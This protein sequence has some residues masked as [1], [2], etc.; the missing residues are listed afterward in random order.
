[1]YFE[2]ARDQ[3]IA[4]IQLLESQKNQLSCPQLKIQTVQ[5]FLDYAKSMKLTRQ[6][7]ETIVE[8]A[9][10]LIDQFYA[11]LPYKRARYATDPVQRLRLIHAQLDHQSD[12]AFHEQMIQVFMRLRDAHTFYGLPRPFRGAFAFLPFRMEC[13]HDKSGHR[14]FLVT[15]VLEGFDHAR[16]ALNAEIVCWNG[17]P[18]E[19]AIEREADLE[20]GGNPASRFVRGMKR[21]TKRSLAFSLPPDESYAVLQYLPGTRGTEQYSIVLPWYVATECLPVA[22]R[23]GSA[24]SLNESLSELANLSKMLW[25]RK[26]RVQEASVA[27]DPRHQSIY[28]HVFEFQYSSGTIQSD[29]VNPASLHDPAYPDQ[30]FGYIRISAFDIDPS[31]ENDSGRFVA[32]FI[33]ILDI[34]RAEAPDGLILDVRSNPGG[35]IDAAERILQLLTPSEIQPAKFHFINSRMTQHIASNLREGTSKDPM[36][37]NHREWLPWADDL[38]ASVSSGH[39]VTPGKPLT[40]FD[41]AND[42]GQRYQS[43][44]MLIVDALSYSA[45][46]LFAAGFQDHQI[47]PIIGVDDNTGGGGAN[48]W[49][50]EELLLKLAGFSEVPLKKLPGGA[51]LGLA[52]RRSTR[53]GSNAG[54]VVEDLGVRCDVKYRITRNDL[55]HHDSDLIQFACHQLGMQPSRQLQILSAGSQPGGIS[56]TVRTQ[57][58]YRIECLINNMPQCAFATDAPQPFFVPTA[59]MLD[60]AAVLR[61]NG[62]ALVTGRSGVQQLQL[63]ATATLTIENASAAVS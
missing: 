42:T 14:R 20:P 33:R 62:F 55:I 13:F 31:Y 21:L 28:P 3:T 18:V 12:L 44:V 19:R 15:S 53:V 41:Q 29:G 34:M 10:L 27:G 5:E 23:A 51:Q 52:I 58:L 2:D 49:L 30:R 22:H 40:G 54:G 7:K 46:D 6:E 9:I 50:H 37:A 16:F 26:Q 43:P 61:V 35:E 59:G 32:E 57:N 39:V 47:G 4:A 11:H 38:R 8:Q 25:H 17:M 60:P 24:S 63:V 1:M 56:V 36:D 45:T 48:R